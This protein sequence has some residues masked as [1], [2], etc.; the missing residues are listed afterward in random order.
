MWC[1]DDILGQSFSSPEQCLGVEV[2]LVRR[3]ILGNRRRSD[4]SKHKGDGESVLRRS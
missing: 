1:L 3:Y 2:L 4:F